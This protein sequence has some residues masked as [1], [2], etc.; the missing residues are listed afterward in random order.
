MRQ[1]AVAVRTRAPGVIDAA[2]IAAEIAAAMHGEDL[3]LGMALEHA[4]EDQVMQRDRRLERIADD[5]VEVEAREALAL[6]EAVRMDHDQ[7]AELLG[8]LPERRKGRIGQLLAGDVG[9]DLDALEA[10]LSSRSARAPCAASWPSCI[11][12]VPQRD[13]AILVLARRYSAMPSLI[14]RAACTAISIGTV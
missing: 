10:E 13:E 9:Q 5:V 4:V 1:V 8:L 3:E 2:G 7:R 6:G 12:T 11:G 14:M